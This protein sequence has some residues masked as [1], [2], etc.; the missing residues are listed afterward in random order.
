MRRNPAGGAQRGCLP[1]A[2]RPEHKHSG[3]SPR[4][5]P[6]PRWITLRDRTFLQLRPAL[7]P[8]P[9]CLG[10]R[11]PLGLHLRTC[12]TPT[13]LSFADT[14]FVCVCCFRR[15]ER[16]CAL[17]MGRPERRPPVPLSARRGVSTFSVSTQ[18]L[19]SCCSQT[20]SHCACTAGAQGCWGGILASGGEIEAGGS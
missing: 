2:A 3:G 19:W 17:L 7:Q 14:R 20:C 13:V 9:L 1:L 12:D 8:S 16:A 15:L 6:K 5:A 18:S 10:A 11:P 4:R